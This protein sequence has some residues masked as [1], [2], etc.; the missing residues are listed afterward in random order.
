MKKL[1][2]VR[3]FLA[4]VVLALTARADDARTLRTL[5]GEVAAGVRT[6]QVDNRSG[7]VTV[8]AV[9]EG[10]GWEWTLRSSGRQTTRLENYADECRLDVRHEGGALQLVVVRPDD[11]MGATRGSKARRTFLSLVTLG[12]LSQDEGQVRSDLTLRVPAAAMVGIKNRFGSVRVSDTQGPTTIDCQNGRVD[13][14]NIDAPVVARTS[15]ASLRVEKVGPAQLTNQN[16][17]VE[18]RDVAGALRATTSFAKLKVS[19]V[20]GDA[21]LKNQNGAIEAARITGDLTAATSFGELRA[22]QIGG[23]ADLKTQNARLESTGISGDVIATTSFGSLHLR[24]TGGRAILKNQNG[25]IEAVRVTGD[26]IAETSFADL[27]I[28]EIGGRADLDCRN[29][30]IEAARV[31]GSVR[32]VN[33]FAPLRVREI[34][35]TVELRGQNGEVVAAGVTGDIRAQTSFARLRL[36]GNGRRFDARNQNGAVEIIANSPDVRHIEA[37]ASF[38]PIE[39]RLPSE[40]KPLI[41]AT[42]SH[43][44]VKSD[45]P[46]LHTGTI[47]DARLAADPAPLK[48]SLTG[49]N[50]EIRIQQIAAR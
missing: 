8:I 27:R 49:Q 47:S 7:N 11:G 38:A 45:F 9:A 46:V 29:G 4:C 23:N 16:G 13:L 14:S 32:A 19:D 24:D 50:S 34:G 3:S 48:V 21:V 36:E 2:F 31:T 39:V 10:F 44:K 22:E 6:L 26:L 35:G 37:S 25:S 33:S 5:S 30:K 12:I 40:S 41:R 20:R 42:T 1:L 17:S 43:G 18:A 28:E 15:F